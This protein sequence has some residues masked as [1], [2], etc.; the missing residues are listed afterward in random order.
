MEGLF[1]T[2]KIDFFRTDNNTVPILLA[3]ATDL[4]IM[5]QTI[6]SDAVM[7][8]TPADNPDTLEF[9]YLLSGSL[10]LTLE[11]EHI[12][13]KTGDSFHSMALHQEVFFRALTD[14]ELLYITNSPLYDSFYGFQNDLEEL[15]KDINDKDEITYA[16][17]KQVMKYAIALFNKLPEVQ[18][19]ISADEMI[20][21]ALFHDVGKCYVPDGILK[22]KDKLTPDEWRYIIKHPTNSSRLLKLRFGQKVAEIAQNHHERMDG[23]GYPFG[24]SG[25]EISFEAKLVAVADV[26]DAMTANRGYNTPKTF[27][28]AALELCALPNKFDSKITTALQALVKEDA[29]R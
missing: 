27:E 22:K 26:F 11:G 9:F 3:K 20:T 2:K 18:H 25:N 4:E 10:Q 14:T 12:E 16:H 6:L 29:L 8:L 15:L 21:A 24:L 5:H 7:W 1:V 23:S 19:N 17:S 13:L 28:E